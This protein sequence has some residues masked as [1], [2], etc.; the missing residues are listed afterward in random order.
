[1]LFNSY[2]FLFVFLPA[3][4][5]AFALASRSVPR[6]VVPLL[7]VLSLAFYGWWNPPHLLLICASILFNFGIAQAMHDAVHLANP[8]R[9]RRLLVLGIAF[10][11]AALGY[12]K[13][14]QF[15]L[16]ALGSLTGAGLSM[17]NPGLP[18]GISFFT[19]TQIAYL[20]DAYRDEPE[21]RDLPS[22]LLFVT[23]FPH[24]I[25][26]PI[27]HHKEMLPQY[28]RLPAY[29]LNARDLAAGITIF[30]L[31]LFKKTVFADGIAPYAD[32]VYS[33]AASSVTT[34]A[35]P[36]AIDCWFG[37]LAYALQIYFDFS[38]YSDMA[39]GL[40]RLFGIALPLNFA[41]PYKAQSIIEF[42][43]RWHMSLSR[44]LRDYL[45]IPLGGNRKSRLRTWINIGITMML[46]GLWHG[47]NW[48]FVAWGTLHGA[49]LVANHAWRTLHP[50]AHLQSELQS[51][52]PWLRAVPVILTFVCVLFA[53]VLF[54][55]NSMAEAGAVYR[56]MFGFNASASVAGADIGVWQQ[57]LGAGA[58]WCLLLL[59]IAWFAPN[60]QQI[61]GRYNTALPTYPEQ[62]QQDTGPLWRDSMSWQPNMKWALI[63]A[64]ISVAAMIAMTGSSRFLYF[65]F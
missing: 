38:G 45:Y 59:A 25:A 23:F 63:M 11:L 37:T 60:T 31:G 49:L 41:S 62:A 28:A 58:P 65:Q 1:V 7:G 48:T 51:R 12:F 14:A 34:G 29:R 53:W 35:A 8:V 13:Y 2:P 50:A 18:L 46:G 57:L 52:P 27:Y 6:A 22:Y 4:L 21:R 61:M 16:E 32:H 15:L 39:I 47:A 55:A 44:F 9:Q 42:W 36:G 3:A 30:M 33:L 24:L 56:G 17:E 5:A 10:N 40:A 43:R 26:G 54:R 19:F 64:A 20:V